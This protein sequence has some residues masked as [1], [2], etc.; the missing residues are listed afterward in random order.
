MRTTTDKIKI[1]KSNTLKLWS[2][3]LQKQKT[4]LKYSRN[5]PNRN[6]TTYFIILYETKKNVPG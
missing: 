4:K 3:S 2:S 1:K 6:M 5:A